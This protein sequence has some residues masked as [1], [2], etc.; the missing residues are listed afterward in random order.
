MRI[1]LTG[2]AGYV[3]SHTLVELLAAGHDVHVI[4]NFCNA[5]PVALDRV[6]RLTGGHFRCTEA[7]LRD[8]P[9]LAA[10][11][12]EFRPEAV[13]HFAGLKAVGESVARPLAYFDA[14]VGGAIA[15]LQ[16]LHGTTCRRLVFSSSATIYGNPDYLP[17]DEAHPVRA[18]NPYG[19]S[20][21]QIEGIL[22]DLAA[23][24]RS[25]SVALLRYFNPVGAHASG[26]IGEDAAGTPNNL[27]PYIALVAVGR[28]STLTVFGD[29]YPTP[30]GTGVRDYIHVCDVARAHLAAIEWMTGHDGAGGRGCEPFNLGTGHGTSVLEMVRAFARASGREIP[31]HFAGR[32]PGDVAACYANANKAAAVLGWRATES[33][34]A[35]CDST[36]AW[37]QRNPSGYRTAPD[38]TA[39]A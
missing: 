31:L 36:W 37:Q 9:A 10:V 30:D 34:V 15:L 33:L 25:W 2:G 11:V 32:R 4:D 16:A 6:R 29:D 18:T 20:K 38:E 7:D 35:M 26:L 3:G 28:R 27:V 8:R 1:M 17:I 14:N 12:A 19:R 24:D 21:L 22:E 39:N 5:S 13:I 23:S